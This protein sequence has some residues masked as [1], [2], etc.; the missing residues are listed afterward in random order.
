GGPAGLDALLKEHA[1]EVAEMRAAAS[2]AELAPHA[3]LREALDAVAAQR[4]AFA[5]GLF[6]YTDLAAAQD[7]ARRDGKLVLSLRL[8]G[9]LDEEYSCANSRFF[10][11]LLYPDPSVASYLKAHFVLHWQ[12]V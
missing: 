4:D 7:A 12:S 1:T 9:R 8:L 3:R 11:T 10:R 2:P 6:W 5:S